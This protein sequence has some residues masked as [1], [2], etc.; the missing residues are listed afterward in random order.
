MQAWNHGICFIR[1]V[2]IPSVTL[3]PET[4]IPDF[5]GY[6]VQESGL[7]IQSL[8]RL[9]GALLLLDACRDAQSG[10]SR[11]LFSSDTFIGRITGIGFA[12]VLLRRQ[13]FC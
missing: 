7:T 10:V 6:N 13:R 8:Y 5:I 2:P 4:R 12:F 1:T 11:V 9:L 3:G